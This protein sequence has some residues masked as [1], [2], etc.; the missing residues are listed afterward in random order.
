MIQAKKITTLCLAVFL[1][2]TSC[3]QQETSYNKEQDKTGFFAEEKLRKLVDSNHKKVED[4]G[5]AELQVPVSLHHITEAE[6]DPNA[7]DAAHKLLDGGYKAY[8]VGGALRDMIMGVE[9]NDFDIATDASNEEIERLLGDVTFHDVGDMTFAVANYPDEGIDVATFYNIPAIYHGQKGIPDFDANERKTDTAENDSFRRDITINS[10]YY[11]MSNGNLITWQGGLYDL[12]E[13]IIETIAD[14]ILECFDNPDVSIR[15]LRFKARY[16]YRF[17][18]RLENA[19]RKYG[20]K[21]LKLIEPSSMSFHL[22]KLFNEG[23]ASRSL[24]VLN[25]YDVLECVF[26][27]LNEVADKDALIKYEQ[28]QMDALDK[29]YQNGEKPKNSLIISAILRPAVD[30]LAKDKTTEEAVDYVLNN[31][32]Q[33]YEFA[34][35]ELKEIKSLLTSDTELIS[36]SES[37]AETSQSKDGIFDNEELNKLLDENHEKVLTE[38]WA[39]LRVPKELHGITEEDLSANALDAGYKLIDAGY[40]AYMIGGAIRD[41]ILGKNP[42]D[43]DI[44]TNA[45]P[46]EYEKVLGEMRFHEDQA[47]RKFGIKDYQDEPVDVATFQNIPKKYKGMDGVPDF[48]ENAL[49]GSSYVDDSFERDLPMNTIYYDLKTGE[50]IDCHDGIWQLREGIIDSMVEPEI[51][52]EALVEAPIRALRFKSRFGFDFSD[53]LEKAFREHG[54][55]YISA[56]TPHSLENQLIKMWGGGYS[57]ACYKTLMEYE[58]FDDCFPLTKDL[59]QT[60]DYQDYVTTELVKMDK[61]DAA[62]G[63]I[64]ARKA[65]AVFLFPVVEQAASKTDLETAISDTITEFEKTFEFWENDGD[66]VADYLMEMGENAGLMQMEEAA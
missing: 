39:E 38:G 17:S 2:L 42:N 64:D 66:V 44:V 55:E 35:D 25:D 14:P 49:Y 50:L 65:I 27:S 37:V 23:Y 5:W 26:P 12:K 43:F 31:Q 7:V 18:D 20:A 53:R 13:G 9:S 15:A 60:A 22:P 10:L 3:G 36:D 59:Y 51:W 54:S 52:S 33:V 56:L 46:E 11:D 19:M 63:E 47:G 24:E 40:E 29:I 1:L 21:F 41:K 57:E 30:E 4:N 6:L 62:G 34:E 32:A 61:D 28:E 16:E 48:D 8:I 45:S 58:L